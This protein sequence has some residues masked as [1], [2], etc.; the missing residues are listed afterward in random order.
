[1][2]EAERDELVASGDGLPDPRGDRL[3]VERVDPHRRVTTGFVERGMR[4]GD[5]GRAARHRL[6]DRHAEPLVER[7]ID[8]HRRSTVEPRDLVV[9]DVAEAPDARVGEIGPLAPA[10]APREHEPELPVEE[11][12]RLDQAGEVLARLDRAEPEDGGAAEVGRRAFRTEAVLRAPGGAWTIRSCSMPSVAVRS[13]AV[14]REFAKTTSQVAAAFRPL[15]VC[16]ETVRAVHHSGWWNGTRSWKTVARTPPR[17]AGY[18]HSLKTKASRRPA[19]E[20]HGRPPEAAPS[21]TERVRRGQ[22]DEPGR[23]RD[24]VERSADRDRPAEA[25]RRERDE[26]VPVSGGR[27]H[28]GKRAADVVP[29]PGAR[30]GERRDV[31]DD[32]HTRS[33]R[34]HS[35][36]LRSLEPPSSLRLMPAP[37][38]RKSRNAPPARGRP[39]CPGS[40]RR[41]RGSAR[42]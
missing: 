1:M 31:D 34:R 21:R 19:N 24:V 41:A 4:R 16:I 40:P 30:M 18:I 27:T 8:E 28:A 29:D 33:R 20:L 11:P 23:G 3:D 15:C 14:K 22:R 5:D 9:G 32:P 26:L 37:P 25:R 10:L 39:C 12:P 17:C 38:A 42:P 6:D 7:G 35:R 2:G 13:A 36:R